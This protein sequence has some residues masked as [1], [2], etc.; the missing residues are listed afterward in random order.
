MNKHLRHIG[1]HF[2]LYLGSIFLSI[3]SVLV[4]MNVITR[5][6]IQ[7]TFTWTEEVAV[8]CFV[9]TIFLGLANAYKTKGLIGVEVLTNL[10]PEKG[11]PAVVFITSLVITVLSSTMFYYSILYFQGSTKVTAALEVS[12][13]YIYASIIMSFG[14]ISIYSIYFLVQSFRKMFINH[15]INLDIEDDLDEHLLEEQLEQ[16]TDHKEGN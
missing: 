11:K 5:Y 4:I 7:V 15:D 2:E 6:F 1:V 13:K 9:W 10:V 12:Y 14:L 3:T 8:G 16:L